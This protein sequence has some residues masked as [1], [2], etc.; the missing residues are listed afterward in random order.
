MG[1]QGI[2]SLILCSVFICQGQSQ[3][4][5]RTDEEH[6]AMENNTMQVGCFKEPRDTI[7]R[8]TPPKGYD[9]VNPSAVI[10]KRC[11]ELTCLRLDQECVSTESTKRMIRAE[12]FNINMGMQR[13]CVDVE[14]EDHVAC[15]CRCQKTQADC[16][17]TKIFNKRMCSCDCLPERKKSCE[18]R[19]LE[20]PNTVMWDPNSCSCPCNNWTECGS[21]E[22]WA[23]EKCRCV[24]VSSNE[25]L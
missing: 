18:K 20:M 1:Y 19:M 9:K 21:G 5:W 15:T 11:S 13:E 25:I 16:G 10:A 24:G 22:F 12:A 7:V 4:C 3:T 2:F 17:K 23:D 6:A 14:V 8:L